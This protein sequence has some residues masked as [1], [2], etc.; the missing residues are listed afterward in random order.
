MSNL[1]TRLTRLEEQVA[2]SPLRR[3]P[4][5]DLAD[6]EP[7]A[8][9]CRIGGVVLPDRPWSEADYRRVGTS[10]QAWRAHEMNDGHGNLRVAGRSRRQVVQS[11][12]DHAEKIGLTLTDPAYPWW[13][14]AE[15]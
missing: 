1:H 3:A 10:V 2:E 14:D 4:R 11:L 13:H 8:E 9:V 15:A 7:L 12:R 5:V 6:N